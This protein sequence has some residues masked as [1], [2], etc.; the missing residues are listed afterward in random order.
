MKTYCAALKPVLY[1]ILM[2]K[3]GYFY[4]EVSLPDSESVFL[5]LL[6]VGP[7]TV[8]DATDN[9]DHG[10]SANARQDHNHGPRN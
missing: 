4:L 9:D 2:F 7:Q 8:A 5:L 6:G 10:K 1:L 3:T